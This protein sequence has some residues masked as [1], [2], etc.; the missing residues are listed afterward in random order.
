[1][2]QRYRGGCVSRCGRVDSGSD[3]P[4]TKDD[5]DS[6]HEML[7]ELSDQSLAQQAFPWMRFVTWTLADIQTFTRGSEGPELKNRNMPPKTS[8]LCALDHPH[9]WCQLPCA[10]GS[11]VDCQS[12]CFMR[13]SHPFLI[14]TKYGTIHINAD[15]IHKPLH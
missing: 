14:Q 8:V 10:V 3:V 4:I 15:V 9:D 1:M 6:W 13:N 11:A 2:M 7:H 5:T 12:E